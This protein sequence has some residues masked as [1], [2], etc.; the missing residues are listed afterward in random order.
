MFVSGLILIIIYIIHKYIVAWIN[1]YN[2]QDVRFGNSIWR[3]TYDYKV[4]GDSD[5]SDLDDKPFV[6]KRRIRNR[7]V[8]LMYCNFFIGFTVLM[9]FVSN[10][11]IAILSK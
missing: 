10:L 7:T 5:I 2:N 9:S 6:R 8:S 11:L 4:L 1:Y 3:W